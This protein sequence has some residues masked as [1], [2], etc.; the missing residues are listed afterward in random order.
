MRSLKLVGVFTVMI[1]AMLCLQSC[2][3]IS[4]ALRTPQA[5]TEALCATVGASV[6]ILAIARANA[7]LTSAQEKTVDNAIAVT[8][9]VCTAPTVPSLADSEAVTFEAAANLLAQYAA[10]YKSPP[11]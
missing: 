6:Q 7:K 3:S 9:P 11:R 4:A 10:S 5:K 1:A 8:S 2:S